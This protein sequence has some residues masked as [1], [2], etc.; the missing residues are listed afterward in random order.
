MKNIYIT[1]IFV[2]YKFNYLKNKM[3]IF[4]KFY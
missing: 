3:E 1:F 4:Y 2:I